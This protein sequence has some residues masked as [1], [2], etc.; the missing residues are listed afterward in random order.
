MYVYIYNVYIYVVIYIY[1]EI[2]YHIYD[3]Y[4]DVYICFTYVY[5]HDHILPLQLANGLEVGTFDSAHP[6][7]GQAL[8]DIAIRTPKFSAEF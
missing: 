7:I 2:C 8:F 3:A 6:V 1:I 4:V 5:Y